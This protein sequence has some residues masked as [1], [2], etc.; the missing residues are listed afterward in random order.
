MGT[1]VVGTGLPWVDA[2]AQSFPRYPFVAFHRETLPRLLEQHGELVVADVHDALPLAFR[3]EGDVAFTWCASDEGVDVVDGAD[4]GTT[5]VDLSEQT[6]SEFINELL[7]ASGAA[8]P[9]RARVT[10]GSLA[11]WQR[12]EP[13]IQ[14]LCSGR[15]IYG[16]AVWDDL[17]DDDGAALDLLRSFSVDD[18]ERVMSAFLRAAGYLHVKDVFSPSEIERYSNA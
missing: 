8:R 17:V 1:D 2:I 15:A 6:F 9:G 7:T 5:V 11:G 14:A 18:D 4:A 12:W 13:A 10:R 16:P 3:I